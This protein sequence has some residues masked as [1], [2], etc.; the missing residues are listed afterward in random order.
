MF[1]LK[2]YLA[3]GRLAVVIAV[4][5]YWYA[6]FV[7]VHNYN[8]NITK[9]YQFPIMVPSF[10]DLRVITSAYDS[11]N[12]DYDPMVYNI[13]D[14]WERPFNYPRI[15]MVFSIFGITQKHTKVIGITLAFVFYMC[16]AWLVIPKIN[17]RTSIIYIIAVWSP[18]VVLGVERGNTD[19]I[20]FI[21]LALAL[22]GLRKSRQLTKIVSCLLILLSS[23]LKLFPIFAFTALLKE[24]RKSF[25]I[26][27]GICVFVFLGYLVLTYDDLVIINKNTPKPTDLTYGS[28]IIFDYWVSSIANPPSKDVQSLKILARAASLILSFAI[29]VLAVSSYNKLKGDEIY[30]ICNYINGFRIGSSIYIGTF[31]LGYNFH[32]RLIFLFFCIPQLI[33]WSKLKGNISLSRVTILL[34]VISMW[35]TVLVNYTNPLLRSII[36]VINWTI[37]YSLTSFLLITSPEWLREI[38]DS[39]AQ[40]LELHKTE[41][42]E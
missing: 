34:I 1:N 18:A 32:Y 36:E 9:L 8:V 28:M 17:W 38:F 33:E 10:A 30:S 15:W 11:A 25:L 39:K 19:L 23:I 42:L 26:F 14:P 2:R 20:I 29:I 24:K 5:I 27:L 35:S 6:Y 40:N 4:G 37:F 13:C 22:L 3:D 16:L 12:L 31:L 41:L 7:G 21:I